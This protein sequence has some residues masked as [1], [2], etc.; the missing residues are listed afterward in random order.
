MNSSCDE[1]MDAAD[2]HFCGPTPMGLINAALRLRLGLLERGK[3][4]R[5]GASILGIGCWGVYDI[6]YY[7][8]TEEEYCQQFRSATRRTRPARLCFLML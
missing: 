2:L 5:R 8:D 4:S 7:R 3:A 6:W 1:A